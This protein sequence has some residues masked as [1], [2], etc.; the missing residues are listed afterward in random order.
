[1]RRSWTP[2][3]VLALIACLLFTVLTARSAEAQEGDRD[4]H[5]SAVHFDL[6]AQPL[7]QALQAF[8]HLTEL[9]VLAP[10]PLLEGRTSAA[11]TGD[12]APRDA[13]EQMLVSTGLHAEFMGPDEAIIAMLPAEPAAPVADNAAASAVQP[14]DG[15]GANEEQRNY[16]GLLQ[17]RLTD[18]LCAQPAAVPG[19]YRLIAQ[20]RIDNRGAVVAVN[21][22][23][24][25]G[26][27]S[28]DAVIVRAM[29]AL[30]LDSAP[31]RDLPQPVTIWLR[32]VDGRVHIRCPQTGAG[33]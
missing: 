5:P 7:A 13:L 15:I 9:V 21:M 1:M 30:K 2:N 4:S 29:R 11:V 18:A 12:Y 31:P 6:P 8:A 33:N 14:D 27:A 20:L 22:V 28:R 25:S 17:A 23:A 32:P 16:A 24:S 26:L 10:A 19:N 3:G